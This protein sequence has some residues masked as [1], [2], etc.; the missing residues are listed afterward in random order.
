MLHSTNV[1]FQ[2]NSS[3][4]ENAIVRA[5]TTLC[6]H[7]LSSFSE[8]LIWMAKCS[9]FP[10][11]QQSLLQTF[12]LKARAGREG[13]SIARVNFWLYPPQRGTFIALKRQ[14][15]IEKMPAD[16]QLGHL[17]LHPLFSTSSFQ[18]MIQG[19]PGVPEI[20]SGLPRGQMISIT[21]PGHHLP[22]SFPSHTCILE[23]SRCHMTSDSSLDSVWKHI[24]KAN[25]GALR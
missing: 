23:F 25:C 21:S 19:S 16:S 15:W 20:F 11:R 9:C 18:S 24:W 14:R 17:Y 22:L 10:S 6:D 4:L 3:T 8:T 1:S 13:E 2:S 12:I 7:C 5:L